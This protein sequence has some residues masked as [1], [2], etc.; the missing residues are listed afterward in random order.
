MNVF[1]FDPFARSCSSIL[2]GAV[3]NLPFLV[4]RLSTLILIDE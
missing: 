4:N 2:N 1:V 3:L